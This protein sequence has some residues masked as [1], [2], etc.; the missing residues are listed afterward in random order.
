[1]SEKN[2]SNWILYENDPFKM[3]KAVAFQEYFSEQ[4]EKSNEND[5]F[6]KAFVSE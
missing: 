2:Q 5:L 3:T 4:I 6:E 1:M